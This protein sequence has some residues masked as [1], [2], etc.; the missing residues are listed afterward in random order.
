MT[1]KFR[2]SLTI[3]LAVVALPVLSWS[4][5]NQPSQPRTFPEFVGTWLLDETASTGKLKMPVPRTLSIATSPEAITVTKVLRL[6][7]EL[8]GREGRRTLTENPPAEVYRFD[9]TD[10]IVAAPRIE[11][12][13]SFRLVA[14]ALA[15]TV[16]DVP[17]SGPGNTALVT[18][19]Y[20]VTGDV[21]TLRRQLSAILMPAGHIATMQEPANRVSHTYVYRRAPK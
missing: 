10:T 2:V 17:T 12:R 18:D 21:L 7:P 8:P 1:T 15:L 4:Q 5:G 13:Y 19:A 11:H 14:D 16:R 3:S 9:G 20:S 6:E